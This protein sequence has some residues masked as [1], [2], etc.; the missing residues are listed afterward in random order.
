LAYNMERDFL[1]AEVSHPKMNPQNNSNGALHWRQTAPTNT[2]PWQ[3]QQQPSL[4][5]QPE[6]S[7][8]QQGTN[9]NP[10]VSKNLNNQ[11]EA[12]HHSN[13]STKK[14]PSDELAKAMRLLE[15]AGT[16]QEQKQTPILPDSSNQH[17]Q[18]SI[19]SKINIEQLF[20]SAKQ[21]ENATESLGISANINGNSNG[22]LGIGSIS[23]QLGK[24]SQKE[25]LE[26][27]LKIIEAVTQATHLG[28]SA[29]PTQL[30]HPRQP[31]SMDPTQPVHSSQ[32]MSHNC[33]SP[34]RSLGRGNIIESSV[35]RSPVRELTNRSL[36]EQ[37]LNQMNTSQGATDYSSTVRPLFPGVK[38]SYPGHSIPHTG[39]STAPGTSTVPGFKVRGQYPGLTTPF[40]GM[41]TDPGT[42]NPYPEVNTSPGANSF[43]GVEHAY[44]E[45]MQQYN[46]K[47]NANQG[48]SIEQDQYS[49]YSR[50][51]QFKGGHIGALKPIIKS[52]INSNDNMDL[53]QQYPEYNESLNS[54]VNTI[55][56]A[57]HHGDNR[58]QYSE[59]QNPVAKN[60]MNVTHHGD[61]RQQYPMYSDTQATPSFGPT[62]DAKQQGGDGSAQGEPNEE[63]QGDDKEKKAGQQEQPLTAKH[64]DIIPGTLKDELKWVELEE[65]TMGHFFVNKIFLDGNKQESWKPDHLK[66]T[67]VLTMEELIVGPTRGGCKL[68]SA[69]VI[70]SIWYNDPSFYASVFP[71]GAEINIVC[72]THKENEVWVDRTITEC[73][74]HRKEFELFDDYEEYVP[75]D[76]G[77]KEARD[78]YIVHTKECA[79]IRANVLILRYTDFCRIV[80]SSGSFDSVSWEKILQFGWYED[81]KYI[82]TSMGENR[83]DFCKRVRGDYMF[84][85]MLYQFLISFKIDC[86]KWLNGIDFSHLSPCVNLLCSVPGNFR[87]EDGLGFEF[88]QYVVRNIHWFSLEAAQL[89]YQTHSLGQGNNVRTVLEK[90]KSMLVSCPTGYQGIKIHFPTED[91]VTKM[92]GKLNLTKN[93]LDKAIV[94]KD[95]LYETCGYLYTNEDPEDVLLHANVFTQQQ[96]IHK[97]GATKTFG[98]FTTGSLGLT[99]SGWGKKPDGQRRD[100]HKLARDPT[101]R[102]FWTYNVNI[103]LAPY[104]EIDESGSIRTTFAPN[105]HPLGTHLDLSKL[106]KY[107]KGVPPYYSFKQGGSQ[108]HKKVHHCVGY[109]SRNKI[110][111]R[112]KRIDPTAAYVT[113]LPDSHPLA[114]ALGKTQSSKEC[115]V[116]L[117]VLR[118]HDVTVL[119]EI[120][121]GI[122]YFMHIPNIHI[123]SKTKNKQQRPPKVVFVKKIIPKDE[124]AALGPIR[125]QKTE[126]KSGKCEEVIDWRTG[127][128]LYPQEK[129][130]KKPAAPLTFEQKM[131][132]LGITT[133]ESLDAY[134]DKRHKSKDIIYKQYKQGS[135]DDIPQMQPSKIISREAWVQKQITNTCAP[136]FKLEGPLA[137]HLLELPLMAN[138]QKCFIE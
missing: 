121:T 33:I 80:V 6:I 2:V 40:P 128:L 113:P 129:T 1:N 100:D 95:N 82:P 86:M 24:M 135:R 5:Q 11:H 94:N 64:P 12:H 41:I 26:S 99:D 70:S 81:F 73:L 97:D 130:N 34:P 38:S 29:Q 66:A 111:N 19:Q 78:I 85:N 58:D 37:T 101:K 55:T 47:M 126:S 109:L 75:V 31:I 122:E 96:N 67:E 21:K 46:G 72:P 98:W 91:H 118:Q 68:E 133:D 125:E 4:P 45:T 15:T 107:P 138:R 23:S 110:N 44:P 18:S 103:L 48:I 83:E 127:E 59:A 120:G 52:N 49:S 9:R 13:H 56:N 14:T 77:C 106:T 32:S 25:L 136:G 90:F 22:S 28:Q 8:W 63:D 60:N 93:Y 88:L 16:F 131:Q 17:G 137:R 112:E 116:S 30:T 51:A 117:E 53:A 114:I 92:W 65:N 115:V 104:S 102:Q 124:L 89:V 69:L 74:V 87:P 84:E 76:C 10:K 27:Q 79:N 57:N 108:S 132:Q 54:I 71:A 35:K 20:H 123:N 134:L 61:N 39:N 7:T 36:Y 105:L 42:G 119:P 43:P 62:G 3:P 50:E